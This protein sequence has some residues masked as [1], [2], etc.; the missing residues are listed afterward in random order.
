MKELHR[1]SKNKELDLRK[2]WT[3][4]DYLIMIN[5]KLEN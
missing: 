4:R 5:P 2:T 1:Q 3:K